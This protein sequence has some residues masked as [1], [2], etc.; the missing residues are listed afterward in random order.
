MRALDRVDWS[1]PLSYVRAMYC[2]PAEVGR[3]IRFAGGHGT[4][5]GASGQYLRVALDDDREPVLLHPTWSVTYL[6]MAAS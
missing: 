4:I 6:G 2:V 5:I 1:D 3:R